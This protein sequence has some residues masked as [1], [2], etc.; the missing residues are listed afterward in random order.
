M[1][2][3][4]TFT[5]RDLLAGAGLI[6]GSTLLSQ[7]PPAR[8]APP[9][10]P[11]SEATRRHK[12]IDFHTHL[13]STNPEVFTLPK[14]NIG[15]ACDVLLRRMDEFNVERAML[16]P[17]EP[18]MKTE[19]Y[20]EAARLHP[21]KFLFAAGTTVRPLNQALD[22][23]KKWADAGAKA[24][25]MNPLTYSPG[26]EAAER[27]IV[28]AVKLK[29]PVLFH[30]RDIPPDVPQFVYHLATRYPE[31]TYVMVHFGGNWGFLQTMPLATN[32]ANVYLETSPDFP[33]LVRTPA[34][35]ML[36]HFDKVGPRSGFHKCLFGSEYVDEYPRVLGA[37]DSLNLAPDVL[38]NLFYENAKRLLK[39]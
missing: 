28:E 1:T 31:G 21:N 35:G 13:G 3:R 14:E 16:V 37:I 4:S 29:L 27:L 8:P 19:Y 26:D 36:E 2:S 38:D 7:Q 25:K 5:R 6:A 12:K 15:K 39:V 11:V 33:N 18:I 17:V 32:L 20:A 34:K 23:L 22:S 9:P 24:L 30:H 10:L